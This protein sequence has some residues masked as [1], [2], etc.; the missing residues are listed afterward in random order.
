MV[1]HGYLPDVQPGQLYGYRVTARTIRPPATA[2]TRTRCCSTPTPRRSAR[3]VRWS[4]EMFGYRIGDPD[5]DLSFDDR[6]NAAYA[7]LAAVIDPSFTWGDDRPPQTPWHKTV[8][9]EAARQGLHEAAPRRARTLR[10]TYLGLASEPAIRHLLDLGVTAVELLPVHHHTTTAHLVERGLSNYW[11]YNTLAFFAPDLRYSAAGSRHGV[12]PRVQ[13]DGPRPARGRH[14]GDPRR[15]LQPHRRRQPPG[16]DAL[17]A[18]HRQRVLL[19]PGRPTTRA[20]TWT[21]PAAATR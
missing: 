17:A 4:D 1:W 20:T 7:P 2:S 12:G 5:A 11:G 6:D 13:D 21:S 3:P 16:P 14:R 19:P 15:G 9:Y 8:I 18:R 10:G